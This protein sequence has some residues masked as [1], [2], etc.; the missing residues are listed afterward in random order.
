[1]F[2]KIHRK[3]KAKNRKTDSWWIIN[4]DIG[5]WILFDVNKLNLVNYHLLNTQYNYTKNQKL[6]NKYPKTKG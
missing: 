3:S 6:K 5:L 2:F 1:M 4:Y